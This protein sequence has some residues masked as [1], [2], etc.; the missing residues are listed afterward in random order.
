MIPT[1]NPSVGAAPTVSTVLV[2][3][4]LATE[5]L[6]SNLKNRPMRATRVASFAEQMAKGRWVLTTDA[7]GFDT[8]GRLLNGQHRLSAIVQSGVAVHMVVAHDLPP[9][10][11]DA[12]DLGLKRTLGD[13][14][15]LGHGYDHGR[16]IAAIGALLVT[17]DRKTTYHLKTVADVRAQYDAHHVAIDWVLSQRRPSIRTFVTTSP[18]LTAV[19]LYY[20]LFPADTMAFL[21]SFWELTDLHSGH[22]ALALYRWGNNPLSSAAPLE[23]FH[24][25]C[26][27]LYAAVEHKSIKVGRMT[28]GKGGYKYLLS[29]R[30]F[31][32]RSA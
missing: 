17:L 14:L 25:T 2:T 7:I 24:R 21:T 9:E 19:A 16:E 3:P 4:A 29:A 8:S 18:V 28:P 5:W 11:M 23:V 27:A 15:R 1:Q 10:S 30:Q 12:I 26:N 20:E 31:L 32:L 13:I 6:R 22:P